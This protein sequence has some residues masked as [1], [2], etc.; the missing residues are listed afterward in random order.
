HFL[1]HA[2]HDRGPWL[3]VGYG[4]GIAAWFVLANRWQWLAL[5]AGCLGV[6]L[7]AVVA[8]AAHG[9]FAHLRQGL[10]AMALVV[11]AGCATVWGKSTLVGTPPIAHPMAPEIAGRVLDRYAQPALGRVRL[12]LALREPRT[13]RPIRVR[14][15]LPI[16]NDVLGLAEGA[17]VRLRAQMMPPRP[18]QLPGSYDFARAAWF[19]GISATGRVLGRPTVLQPA[20]GDAWLARVQ[21]ALSVHVRARLAGSPGG[22]AAAF[23]SG[24]RGGIGVADD[25]AMRD[26]GLTHLLS[27]SG[28][29]VSAV[30]GGAF[31]LTMAV[32]A[33]VPALALRLRLPLVAA[34]V[35]GA[36]GVA[37]TLL[38][39]AEVPTVRSCLGALLVLGAVALGRQPLSLR[40][41][42]A[43]ALAVM[44]L[45]PESV[46][47]PGFQMSF[48]S[49]IAIIAL[50]NCAPVQAFLAPR[51]ELALV[52]AGRHLF[53]ILL[54]GM[55]IDLALTPIALFHF[56]RAG[57]Y[58]SIANVIAIPLTTF[59]SMPMIALALVL[60]VAGAGWPAWWVV[61]KSLELL[62][63]I[64]HWTAAQPGAVTLLPA[65]GAGAFGL[66]V[67]G[68]LWLALWRGS[69]RLLGLVPALVATL[70]LSSL[71]PAD[72]LITGDGRNLGVVDPERGELLVLR[73]GRSMFTRD[74]M[75]ELTG[76]SGHAAP[77]E[78][79][80][81]A[82]CNHDFCLIELAR[83]GRPWRI[84]VARG[85]AMVAYADQA[86]ACAGVDIVVAPHKLFGPCRP[87]ML[88]ADKV[89]LSR[90]GGIA[91][92]L[93]NR[94]VVTVED[95]EG[96][97]P[98]WRAPH[99]LPRHLEDDDWPT[100]WGLDPP[101]ASQ[102]RAGTPARAQ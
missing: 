101:E 80:P 66:F 53:M 98:W 61:G 21:H 82:R 97:H 94:R 47:S 42:A 13:D 63:S 70:M 56:H 84:L 76:M 77:L 4:C 12:V 24:D 73:P 5:L 16:A 38:T 86:R 17:V 23:A 68:M 100:D 72:L 33:L 44:L 35:A 1:H 11:A 95:S 64:A 6:A 58:G 46:V 89:L 85:E 9:R 55:V 62:L 32:L 60:D 19:S 48:G 15:T 78:Q 81:G 18:P 36:V 10:I 25:Q 3:A 39:G 31:A 43:A 83:G 99:R 91:L 87:A 28:L 2:G 79:W 88:K 92:D 41:L 20:R 40:L 8:M 69:V 75:L 71:R 37:Y 30:V 96:E 57:I 74:A 45:W 50:H 52:R 29:H 93:V 49:V 67:A 90:T 102:P 7:L 51:P 22:I 54:T 26:A 14:L 34:G 59:V 65:M 27:V